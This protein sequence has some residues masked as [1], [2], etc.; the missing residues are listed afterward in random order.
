MTSALVTGGAGFIGVNLTRRLRDAGWDVTVFDDL[1]VGSRE[2]VEAAGGGL[3]VGD[4]LDTEAL[5]EAARGRDVLFHLAAGAG[6]IDSLRDP[7]GN[8]RVNAGGVVS[9][10]WAAR[11]AEVGRVVFSSSNAPLGPY[12]QPAS[13]D[14]P[15][16]PISPYGASKMAGEAYA[17][18]FYESYGLETVVVRFANAYGPHSRHKTNVIPTFIRAIETGDPLVVYGDGEQTRDFVYVDDLCEGLERAATVPAAAGEIFQLASGVETSVA[19]LLRQLRWVSRRDLDVERRAARAGE[20]LRSYARIDKAHR[21][22][23]LGD[24][25]PLSEGLRR[26][27]EWFEATTRS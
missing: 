3:V 16:R 13:E 23:N 21:V 19:E 18:A 4:V 5:T 8:F 9:A 20:V 14:S 26:T 6:V 10:L 2:A 15:L 1:S 27:W 12:A 11:Q 22:L 17:V 7:I 24:P 25:V